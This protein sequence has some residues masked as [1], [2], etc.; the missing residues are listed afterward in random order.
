[1]DDMV[2]IRVNKGKCVLI[3]E[4]YVVVGDGY[5]G[6]TD[7][8]IARYTEIKKTDDGDFGWLTPSDVI[9]TNVTHVSK[10][11]VKI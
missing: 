10:E 11:P 2:D 3:D 7:H 1:M 4:Y 6:K 9:I 5:L 8:H